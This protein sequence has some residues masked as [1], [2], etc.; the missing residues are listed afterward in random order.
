MNGSKKHSGGGRER[1]G[2]KG[3]KDRCGKNKKVK[4]KGE[5]RKS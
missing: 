4:G 5:I 1:G 2:I 3:K